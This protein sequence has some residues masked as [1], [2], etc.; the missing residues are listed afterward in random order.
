M[1]LRRLYHQHRR[2]QFPTH[3]ARLCEYFGEV[4]GMPLECQ[5]HD[6]PRTK[7]SVGLIALVSSCWHRSFQAAIINYY[8]PET[9]L[10]G[11]L[12]NVELTFDAPI[13]SISLGLSAIFLYAL[14]TAGKYQ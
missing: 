7:R 5:V 11:H 1:G 3:L 12:D 10:C 6:R 2:D 13:V 8:A 14:Y 4:A 9:A